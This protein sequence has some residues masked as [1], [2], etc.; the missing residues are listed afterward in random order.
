MNSVAFHR[1]FIS[2]MVIMPYDESKTIVKEKVDI[3]RDKCYLF[4]RV[5]ESKAILKEKMDILRDK[6]YLF[7]RV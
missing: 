4:G 7:A 5:G 6:G 3:L 2:L 1:P